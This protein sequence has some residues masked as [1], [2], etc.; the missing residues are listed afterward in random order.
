MKWKNSRKQSS[1]R[2]NLSLLY[3]I[4]LLI[5][6]EIFDEKD[7][8]LT[9]AKKIL[10]VYCELAQQGNVYTPQQVPGP[11][12]APKVENKDKNKKWCL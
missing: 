9:D 1:I 4:F 12:V 11:N 6:G 2:Q 3:V 7:S 10:K 8:R 5:L